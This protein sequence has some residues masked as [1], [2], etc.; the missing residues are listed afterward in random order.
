MKTLFFTVILLCISTF[1]DA[2]TDMLLNFKTVDGFGM[3][4]PGFQILHPYSASDKPTFKDIPEDIVEYSIR[5][6]DI[7]PYNA[8]Y[9][10]V[11]TGQLSKEKFENLLKSREIDKKLVTGDKYKHALNILFGTNK[12]NEYVIIIDENNNLSFSDDEK[13]ILPKKR[14]ADEEA[15]IPANE[16]PIIKTKFEYFDGLKV[17]TVSIPL[18]IL[19]YKGHTGITFSD[20]IDNKY[21]LRIGIP[22]YKSQSV[23]INNKKYILN[24]SNSFTSL[25]YTSRNTQLLIQSDKMND[26]KKSKRVVPYSVGDLISFDNLQYKFEKVSL[27]GDT[28][29]LKYLGINKRPEGFLSGTYLP[30]TKIQTIDNKDFDFEEHIGKYVLIDFWGSWCV[31]C[32]KLIPRIAEVNAKYKTKGLV[33]VSVAYDDNLSKLKELIESKQMNWI[34]LIQ[35][36]NNSEFVDK[37]KVSSFPTLML[38]D[39]SGKILCRDKSIDEIDEILSKYL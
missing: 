7:Q 34:H 31:P 35:S 18:A 36:K 15:S 39:P 27:W 26:L 33:L 2:Q 14:N 16:L 4:S 24:L 28:I 38:V 12:Q 17:S 30:K 20:S 5:E 22:T 6:F 8:G 11:L 25:E 23:V 37:L 21:C 3:F 1:I 19:P 13:L 10:Y 29:S 32:I 9:Q